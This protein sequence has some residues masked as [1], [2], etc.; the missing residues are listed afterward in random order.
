MKS[1]RS[2]SPFRVK[3]EVRA[4]RD[5]FGHLLG[6][7][8]ADLIPVVQSVQEVPACAQLVKEERVRGVGHVHVA[9]A[10]AVA[11]G[12]VMHRAF[13]GSGD[14][15]VVYD[16]AAFLAFVHAVHSCHGLHEV[17]ALHGLVHVHRRQ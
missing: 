15:D 12:V 9:V 17:V 3:Q 14:A 7:I 11:F 6:G 13:Q 10:F 2:F 1:L 5:G 16:Q 8:G 4:V